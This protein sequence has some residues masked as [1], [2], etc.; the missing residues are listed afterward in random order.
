MH[1]VDLIILLAAGFTTALIFGY[2]T[3]R[4][5]LSPIVG[6]LFAGIV[7]GPFT[8]GFV[9]D[10]QLAS[11]LAEIGVILLMFGVGLHFHLADLLR[12]RKIAIPGAM[13]QIVISTILGAAVAIAWGWS[14]G[15]G[16]VAGVAISV[17]STVV[18]TRVLIDNGVLDSPQGHIAVGWLIVEDIF[19]VLVLVLLPVYARTLHT[20]GEAVGGLFIVGLAM[21]KV[22][23]LGAIVLLGGKRAIPWLLTHIARTQSRELFTLGVLAIAITIATASAMIFGAS[24]A[25]GAFLAGMVVGQSRAGN[26]AA[27]DALPLRDAFAV[28]FFVSVGMLFN[29][30]FLIENP[31]LILAILG[32]ILIAK[33]VAALLLVILLGYSVRAALTAAIA[34]AQIGEFSFILATAALSLGLFTQEGQ[35]AL[36]AA[37]LITISLNP[38]L[39][40][41]VPG[42]ERRLRKRPKLWRF[43][44]RRVDARGREVNKVAAARAASAPDV[45]RAIVIGYG[46]VGQTVTRILDDFNIHPVIVELNIDTVDQLT[47]RGYTAFYGDAARRGILT[48][49]G[50]ESAKFL[51]ITIP[52]LVSRIP[53]VALARE[54][55]PDIIILVR[56]R[57]LAERVLLEDLGASAVTYEEVEA[58][59]G[60][61]QYLLQAVGVEEHMIEAESGRIREE[62]AIRRKII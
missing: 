22:F 1:S 49:A 53:V 50:I 59:V 54:M 13:G 14:L 6:Y 20:N 42:I 2:I 36:V 35:S 56:A 37:A 33:P 21:L 4:L 40:R 19:T 55:N 17:A 60:L 23:A 24:F 7:V 12:V 45:N 31:G 61:S 44:N 43:L 29:P 28:L 58:A 25:L 41:R 8:P 18:L 9:A 26:Q 47:A 3:E 46:P 15:N 52:D 39:F 34:L 27:A 62:F 32:I 51:I 10:Q 16:I 5:G 48:A 38:I 57:Y 30:R 11:Q